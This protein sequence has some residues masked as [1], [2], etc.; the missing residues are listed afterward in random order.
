MLPTNNGNNLPCTPVS[1]NC[2][3]WQGPDI[4]CINLCNGDTIS[5]VVSKLATE[6]CKLIDATCVCNPDLTGLDLNCLTVA[7]PTNLVQV[8]NAVITK[9]CTSATGTSTNLNVSSRRVA[10]DGNIL[11]PECL[12]YNDE[13]GNPITELPVNEFVVY[14]ANQ[15]CNITSLI[16]LVNNAIENFETRIGVLENCVL[17]CKPQKDVITNVVSSCLFPGD[18]VLVSTLLLAIEKDYC[19]FKTSVGTPQDIYN[20]IAVQGVF[21]TTKMLSS[22]STYGSLPDWVNAPANL[23]QANKDQWIVLNDLYSAVKDIQENFVDTGCKGL[24]NG[25]T[26]NVITDGSGVPIN[27]NLNFTSTSWPTSYSDCGGSTNVKV[28]DSLGNEINQGVN[29]AQLQNESSGATISLSSLNVN[30]SLT[31]KVD[32]CGTDGTNQCQEKQ[33]IVIPL[34]TVCPTDIAVSA[35]TE[36]GAT[37]KFTNALGTGVSY[38]ID[39][40]DST[41]SAITSTKTLSSPAFSVSEIF[42]S[43]ASGTNYTVSIT[44]TSNG[45]PKICTPVAFQT[46]GIICNNL[47]TST[48]GTAG[49]NDIYL[50][51]TFSGAVHTEYF[52]NPDTQVVVSGT[53][54]VPTC[55]APIFSAFSINE[56]TGV[57][58]FTVAYGTSPGTSIVI[59]RSIDGVTYASPSSIAP[60]TGLT[61]SSGVTSGVLYLRLKTICSSSESR[62]TIIRYDFITNQWQVLQSPSNCQYDSVDNACPAGVQV[63]QQYLSCGTDTYTVFSGGIDSYWFFIKKQI[64]LGVTF[65]LY[66]G[67]DQTSGVTTVVECCACPAFI[68]TDQITVFCQEGNST[69]ITLPYVLGNGIPSMNV[70]TATTNGTLVQAASGGNSFTYTHLASSNSYADTFAVQL[71]PQVIGDCESLTATIQIQVVPCEV[72]MVYKDQPLFVFID[73]NSFTSAEGA[74]LKTGFTALAAKWNTDWGYTGTVYFI[75]TTSK[76]WLGYQKAIVDD[77]VSASLSS[78]TAWTALQVIPTSWSSGAPIYKN[79][80]M[81]IALSNSSEGVYHD[82]TLAAGFGSGLTAQPRTEYKEDY[83]ALYDA[84]NGTNTSTWATGLGIVRN[85]YPDGFSAVYNPFTVQMS[86][87]K[88]AAAVLQGLASY[89]GT[90]IPPNQYGIKTAVDITGY[91]LQGLVPSATNPYNGATT[92]GSNTL[93][94][95]Y[96]QGFMMYLNNL[97][98]SSTYEDISLGNDTEFTNQ[99][100]LAAQNCSG[101]YPSSAAGAVRI[102]VLRCG[103]GATELLSYTGSAPYPAV[104]ATLKS[105]AADNST[106]S[107]QYFHVIGYGNGSVTFDFSAFSSVTGCELLTPITILADCTTG[108]QYSVQMGSTTGIFPGKVYK[109]TNT[110]SS[111]TPGGADNWLNGS[112]RC[113][114]VLKSVVGTI[115]ISSVTVVS[116]HVNCTTCTP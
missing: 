24:T 27:I 113:L 35:I 16:A 37:V 59:E 39:I 79:G 69:T 38:K 68:L 23:S 89:V 102:K 100:T 36:S 82:S 116:T 3:I 6:L 15:I 45:V 53:P 70:T 94:A 17:P 30:N 103:T 81:L 85:Q 57:V 86:G 12:Y 31:V 112:S 72:K 21:G 74:F 78:V 51:Y 83:D 4:A 7:D 55:F 58:T 110:G 42:S 71:I 62:F 108:Y 91:L 67:W 107:D 29:I 18:S 60:G 106:T 26:Y 5:S 47:T 88:D 44:I 105:L 75:P 14:L 73:T 76:R 13:F 25:F 66:A 49:S 97:K 2:V 109:L 115:Q 87:T 33:S 95:L 28:I 93:Q 111:F 22:I 64:R 46:S 1:S 80:A 84:K 54:A 52:Y 99:L 43:L 8:L 41:T 20:A 101:A 92:G 63:A 19:A 56:S 50:G 32:F 34:Q 90:M 10:S 98:K 104:N 61:Y 96:T 48:T 40:V 65:Y 9:A 114:T 77:G 11:L